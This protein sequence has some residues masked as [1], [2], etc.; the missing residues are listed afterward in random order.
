MPRCPS[1]PPLRSFFLPVAARAESPGLLSCLLFFVP[2]LSSRGLLSSVMPLG[3]FSRAGARVSHFLLARSAREISRGAAAG[4]F[5]AGPRSP[6]FARPVHPSAPRLLLAETARIAR[7]RWLRNRFLHT[8]GA[9]KPRALRPFLSRFVFNR[10]V[11]FA[12][13]LLRARSALRDIFDALIDS[14]N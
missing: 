5:L 1:L 6:L 11:S 2:A 3:S 8:S 10:A 7:L 14:V 4:A 12:P 9:V 13:E